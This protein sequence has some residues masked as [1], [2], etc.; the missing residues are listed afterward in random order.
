MGAET[1]PEAP[2]VPGPL[3]MPQDEFEAVERVA[4]AVSPVAAAFDPAE[5]ASLK[6]SCRILANIVAR[7]H[8]A[9]EAARIE[10]R[11]NGP[12]A[13]MQWVLNSLPDVWDDDETAWDGVES[14]QA[15]FDRTESFYRA[16]KEAAEASASDD[17]GRVLT[18]PDDGSRARAE[19]AER[20]LAEIAAYIL[21][22]KGDAG[23]SWVHAL[24]IQAIISGEV[25]F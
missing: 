18:S 15:W 8:Q 2:A 9:M 25:P 17:T 22:H 23:F 7:N 10:M 20:K 24:D 21:E 19:A 3:V 1:E 12:H 4:E 5:V 13:G 6:R 11:Q 14:A 16:A